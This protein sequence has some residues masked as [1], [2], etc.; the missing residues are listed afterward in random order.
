MFL[1]FAC[2]KAFLF[3]KV[4][5][6]T[7]PPI[8][9]DENPIKKKGEKF[10]FFEGMLIIHDCNLYLSPSLDYH[11]QFSTQKNK[12]VKTFFY[13]TKTRKQKK[14]TFSEK[15]KNLKKH[16][17]FL[18]KRQVFRSCCFLDN[19]NRKVLLLLCF[20]EIET[21]HFLF[22]NQKEHCFACALSACS[23]F[24]PFSTKQ[25]F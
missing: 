8:C 12:L 19:R 22:R 13:W 7:Q 21:I 24:F 9:N 17:N 1:Y 23:P 3:S 20:V 11:S 25:N 2:F 10:F 4:F 16:K 5:K 14:R 18:L 15:V 6:Y